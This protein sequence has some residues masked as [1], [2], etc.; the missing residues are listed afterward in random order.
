MTLAAFQR[1]LAELFTSQKAR[2][3]YADDPKR[4]TDRFG[5]KD[6]EIAQLDALARGPIEAYAQ[7][8]A[9][10]QRAEAAR[11]T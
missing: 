8:L 5:L 3:K 6:R 9:R 4:F 7:T 1:A 10:K 2:E 11:K